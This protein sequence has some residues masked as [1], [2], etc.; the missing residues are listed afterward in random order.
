MT[1]GNES[2]G[3]LALRMHNKGIFIH[4]VGGCYYIRS[5]FRNFRNYR[6]DFKA[7]P[8]TWHSGSLM[9]ELGD[10]FYATRH[11][12]HRALCELKRQTATTH[13]TGLPQ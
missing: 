2:L 1:Q 3:P 12:I 7:D 6:V 8:T 10:I 4:Q 9:V 11:E 5:H 13:M